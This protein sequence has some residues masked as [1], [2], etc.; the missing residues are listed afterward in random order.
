[1]ALMDEGFNS[2]RRKYPRF[3]VNLPVKY[4]SGTHFFPKDCRALNAS[5]EG[6]LVHL[7]EEIVTG[8]RLALKLFL[9]SH[10]E[11]NIIS[12]SV[13]VVWTGIHMSKDFTWAYR[14]GVRF[15]DIPPKDMIKYKNFLMSLHENHPILS[16]DRVDRI[17][18]AGL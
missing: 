13:Q 8:H 3:N 1:M 14:T 6:L 7:P 9:H 16:N 15:V 11:L 2:E 18:T 12:P 5:E 17:K 4:N 10:S